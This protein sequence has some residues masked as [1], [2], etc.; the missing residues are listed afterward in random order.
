MGLICTSCYDNK[1]H[2]NYVN[3]DKL[4]D[5]RQVAAILVTTIDAGFKLIKRQP[6]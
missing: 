2:F 3:V 1:E 4:I 6:I 5:A